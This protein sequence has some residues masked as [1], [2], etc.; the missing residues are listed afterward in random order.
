MPAGGS[1]P[2][3]STT[4]LCQPLPP[5]HPAPRRRRPGP[6]DAVAAHCARPAIQPSL[7]DVRPVW[8]GWFKA[9][10][11][12][13]GAHLATVLSYV[14]RNSMRAELVARAEHWKW[15]GLA[16]WL[17]GAP[18]LSPG[19]PPP[20]DVDWVDRVNAPLSAA[21]LR[22]KPRVRLNF[23]FSLFTSLRRT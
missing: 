17:A 21:D 4:A 13:D 1:S 5:R 8:Q 2:T 10:P 9:I 12:Q 14:E 11:V 3:S 23:S 7:Q 16:R 22:V 18:S 6:V 19:Q 20:R 15:F